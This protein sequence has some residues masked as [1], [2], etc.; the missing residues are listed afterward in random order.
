MK[1]LH[2]TVNLLCLTAAG[3]VKSLK[4]QL[5]TLEESSSQTQATLQDLKQEHAK[6]SPIVS[7][8]K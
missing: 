3:E 1:P 6:V 7:L 4:Q 2:F 8:S 5:K